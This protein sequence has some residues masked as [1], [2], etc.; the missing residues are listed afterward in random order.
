MMQFGTLRSA[1]FEQVW[2][3]PEYR[4]L[5]AQLR[6]A[7]YVEPCRTCVATNPVM[8]DQ[9]ISG[10]YALRFVRARPSDAGDPGGVSP[11]PHAVHQTDIGHP[12]GHVRSMVPRRL[13]SRLA[14]HHV[15][16][17]AGSRVPLLPW[18]VSGLV[19]HLNHCALDGDRLRLSGWVI[20]CWRPGRPP[21][22]GVFVNG[23][24]LATTVT[25]IER[26]DVAQAFGRVFSVID[27]AAFRAS[28]SQ[29]GGWQRSGFVL[30]IDADLAPR[31]IEGYA[32]SPW[33]RL[34]RGTPR[35]VLA[36][37]APVRGA[38]PRTSRT[39]RLVALAGARAATELSGLLESG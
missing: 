33:R 3:G 36:A 1:S 30:E 2:S 38:L 18:Y 37:F 21:L 34:L 8:P 17:D 19:G 16:L 5:R 15:E 27:R 22:V 20:D 6:D 13:P 12:A 28:G 26:P 9:E 7:R 4:A 25:S 14:R 10:V 31:V 32:S 11:D 35:D 23:V 29:S 24:C 39:T